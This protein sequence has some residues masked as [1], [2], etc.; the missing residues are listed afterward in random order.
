[1]IFLNA[2][3]FGAMLFLRDHVQRRIVMKAE[4]IMTTTVMTVAPDST[5]AHAI[6]LMLQ[7][8]ISGL[9]VV[10][11]AGRL[12]GMVTEGDLL[13]RVE[14]G[15]ERRRPRWLEFLLGPGRLAEEYTHT[16]GRKVEE[17]MT[18]SP[19]TASEGTSLDEIVRVME[20]RQIKRVPIVRGEQ[21]VGIVSR[22]NLLHALASL[23][24]ELKPASQTDVAIREQLLKH[25]SGRQ[26]APVGALD[27][28]VHDGVVELW[29]TITDERERQALIVAAE[30]VPGVKTVRDHLAWIDTTTGMLFEAPTQEHAPNAKASH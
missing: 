9:P 21:L 17:V 26:W 8:K 6:R 16:H 2:T 19:V 1:L 11:A 20:K 4:D 28:T 24:H 18:P 3:N 13:R 14:T 12:V 5:V 15:T 7:K 30:N 27:I 25:L 22:A 23:S 29:G 10:N